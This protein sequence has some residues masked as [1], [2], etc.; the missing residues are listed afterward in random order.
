MGGR[1]QENTSGVQL[2]LHAGSRQDIAEQSINEME[3]KAVEN[4]DCDI[5]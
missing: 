1:A 3:D 4:R 2:R 5:W